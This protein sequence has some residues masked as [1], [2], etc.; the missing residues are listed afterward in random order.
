[1]TLLAA[2]RRDYTWGANFGE[3]RTREY[4]AKESC[5]GPF[6]KGA[7]KPVHFTLLQ[8]TIDYLKSKDS[9]TLESRDA[10]GLRGL[11]IKSSKG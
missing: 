11:R 6:S 1:M 3:R 7:V 4:F 2:Y 9:A 8:T 10:I 5:S